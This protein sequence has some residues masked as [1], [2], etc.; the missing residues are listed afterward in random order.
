MCS[1]C[2]WDQ[3]YEIPEDQTDLES[4]DDEEV[5]SGE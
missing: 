5:Y 3:E 2:G 4:E 1:E